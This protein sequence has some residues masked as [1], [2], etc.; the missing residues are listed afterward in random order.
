MKY[1]H[2][3]GRNIDPM[4]SHKA[5]KGERDHQ[6]V[7][8]MWGPVMLERWFNKNPIEILVRYLSVP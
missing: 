2:I 6:C 3:S 4:I 8:T 7:G 5:I 1:P